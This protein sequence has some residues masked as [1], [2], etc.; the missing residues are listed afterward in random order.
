[1]QLSYAHAAHA[2]RLYG[3]HSPKSAAATVSLTLSL[4]IRALLR[5]NVYGCVQGGSSGY[6]GKG[7][8]SDLDNH[9][10]QLN[11]NNPK[12]DSAEPGQGKKK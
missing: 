12:H 2:F 6:G 10:D 5:V 4:S 11:P 3:T 7:D 9:A 1:M 8:K